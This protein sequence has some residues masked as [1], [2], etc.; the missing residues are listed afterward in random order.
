[1]EGIWDIRLGGA[2][3]RMLERVSRP[4]RT[5]LSPPLLRA[6]VIPRERLLESLSAAVRSYRLTLVSAPAGYGKTTLLAALPHACPD[7]PLGW[8]SLEEEDNDPASF[9]AALIAALKR[10]NPDCCSAAQDLL[11]G[12]DNPAPRARLIIGALI[13]EVL[14]DMP[15]PFVLVLDDLHVITEPAIHAAL[16]YLI[17][18]LPQQMRLAV[19]T[20]RDP[21]LALA[22]LRAAAK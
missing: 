22:R 2:N 18:R 8:L 3:E 13:N 12:L 16:G 4:V 9:L 5:K 1:M 10:L 17:E 21:P 15:E 14:E 11:V 20:R 19:A 6:D 7:L